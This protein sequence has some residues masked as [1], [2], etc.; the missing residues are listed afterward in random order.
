MK[1]WKV[2]ITVLW[3]PLLVMGQNIQGKVIDVDTKAALPYVNIGVNGQNL[4]TISKEDGTFEMDISS[5]KPTD[6]IRFSRIGYEEVSMSVQQFSSSE[7][8]IKMAPT[9]YSISPIEVTAPEILEK[10][11]MGRFKPTRTTSGQTGRSAYGFGGEIGLQIK[12]EGKPYLIEAVNFHYR[13]FTVDSVLFRINIY[14]VQDGQPGA[15]LL[16]NEIFVTGHHKEKWISKNLL[17]ENLI[18]EEDIIVTQE[19]IRIWYGEKSSNALFLTHGK[20]Y[21]QGGTYSR[22]SS[23]DQWRYNARPPITLYLDV[24]LLKDK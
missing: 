4:G 8:E 21:N 7:N 1:L 19:L 6:T 20:G 17:D 2:I 9:S 5:I 23:F 3:C 16:S 22:F 13:F 24:S 10:Q 15:S 18:I 12:Y 11:K 14:R